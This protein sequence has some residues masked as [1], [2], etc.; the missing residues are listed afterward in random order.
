MN[1]KS[2][3]FILVLMTVTGLQAQ[4]PYYLKASKLTVSGTSSLHDWVSDVTS[5]EWSGDILIKDGKIA[6][7]KNVQAKML[8]T[9]IKSTK[10]RIMDSKTYDAF[11]ADKNPH[12]TYK[13]AQAKIEDTG[14]E[15]TISTTGAL[16][17]AGATKSIDMT[18]KAK[19]LSNGDIQLR[20]SK[21]LNMRDY[22]MEPP[23]AMMGTIKVGE[24]VTIDFDLTITSTKMTANKKQ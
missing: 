2:A 20:G 11:D 14:T 9:S 5:L 17:M 22:K 6:E 7:I 3:I 23:T 4:S 15:F 10:G 18:L 12:I 16:T 19:L 21:K 13:L 24:E 1:I 8:V